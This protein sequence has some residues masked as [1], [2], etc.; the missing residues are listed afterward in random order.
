M[1]LKNIEGSEDCL[2]LN[3]YTQHLPTNTSSTS[4]KPVMVWIHGGG[5]ETGSSNTDLYGPDFLMTEDIVLVT[6]NYRLGILGFLRFEDPSLGVSGN[7][8][9]KDMVMALKWVQKNIQNFSGDPNNVTIF[10]ESAGGAAVHYLVLSPLA[11]G[12]FHKAIAQSGSALN[13]FSRG[14]NTISSYLGS[15]LEMSSVNEK[16]IF[17]CLKN[18]SVEKLFEVSE[19][20]LEI[21]DKINNSGEKRP[22]GPVIEDPSKGAFLTEDPLDIIKSGNYN[23]IPLIFGYTTREGMLIE[24]MI[25]PRKPSIPRDFERIVPYTLEVERGS[26]ARKNIADKIKQFYY[27]EPGSES[28]LDN[29]YLLHTDNHFLRD[30]MFATEHHSL[31]S[32]FPVYLY[33]MSIETKLNLF[34]TIGNIKAPGVSHGD[35]IGYLFKSKM[36]PKLEPGSLEALSVRRFVKYWT[37]FAK[38]GNPNSEDILDAPEW[39]PVKKDQLNLIDIGERIS[40]DVNPEPERMKFWKEIFSIKP[41]YIV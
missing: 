4:L 10:G 9:L 35:D 37:N 16:E 28:L 40:T 21:C 13:V 22:Y 24:M 33:R 19:K 14:K 17:N 12:L 36:T 18:M 38:C 8:G 3:V 26:E 5:F 25:K 2:F 15:A 23:Q 27:G 31:T 34:K 41:S 39:K 6:L 30:I 29:F 32:K 7:A 1:V 11:K 20:V